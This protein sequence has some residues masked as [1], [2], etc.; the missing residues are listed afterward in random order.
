MTGVPVKVLTKFI[1]GDIDV[2]YTT[3]VKDYIKSVVSRAS[4][5]NREEHV[6]GLKL[7]FARRTHFCFYHSSILMLFTM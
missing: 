4:V 3:G 6:N 5:P 7:L 1:V 2:T